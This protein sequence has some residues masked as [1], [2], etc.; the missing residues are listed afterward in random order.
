MLTY[1]DF[2]QASEVIRRNSRSN[3][4]FRIEVTLADI[5]FMCQFETVNREWLIEHAKRIAKKY[6][7]AHVYVRGLASSG[8]VWESFLVLG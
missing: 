6:P 3:E 8:V 7:D 5:P 2:E 1:E 4:I